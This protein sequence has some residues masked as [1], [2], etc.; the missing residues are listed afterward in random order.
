MDEIYSNYE[1]HALEHIQ[2]FTELVGLKLESIEPG[3]II[4]YFDVREELTNPRGI[5]HGGA[6]FTLM[7]TAAGMAGVYTPHGERSLV[8]QCSTIHF[9]RMVDH[10]K[11]RAES[12]LI[13]EGKNVSLSRVDVYDE[14][15][16]L[17]ATG[18]FELFYVNEQGQSK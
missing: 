13:K 11:V 2:G 10:G 12:R 7:D 9:L 8:T 18:D 6:I 17:A 1:K 3:H 5:V 4:I 14:N 16:K 15:G